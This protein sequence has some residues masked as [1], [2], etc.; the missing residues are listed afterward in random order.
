M[1][2]LPDNALYLRPAFTDS[3]WGRDQVRARVAVAL[4]EI[5]EHGRHT[6]WSNSRS[7]WNEWRAPDLPE[8]SLNP[9]RC[10]CGFPVEV[11]LRRSCDYGD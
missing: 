3:P 6:R 8:R 5:D 1:D 4:N 7:Q 10:G 9:H 2:E 11:C